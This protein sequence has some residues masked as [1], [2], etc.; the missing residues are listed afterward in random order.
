MTTLLKT[1]ETHR[2][3]DESTA[4]ILIENARNDGNFELTKTVKQHK[5]KTKKGE[6]VE[7]FYLV[8]LTKEYNV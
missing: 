6:I 7:D 2:A 5:I 4:D 3:E 1:V 8:T